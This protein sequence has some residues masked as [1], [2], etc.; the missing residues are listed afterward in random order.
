MAKATKKSTKKVSLIKQVQKRNGM[1]VPFDIDRITNAVN[2]AMIATGEGSLE[3]AEMVANGVYA[4][5]VRISKK[6]KNFL[7]TV[8]GIQNSVE[9]QLMLSEYIT[10]AKAY[11]LYR[12]KRS[13]IRYKGIEVPVKVKQLAS[14]SKKDFR[15]PL[16][17]FVY[18]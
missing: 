15:N 13:A 4:D 12:E 16:G 1:I 8:E 5:L 18:Y 7:P 10:T 3:E 17:E 2:K 11:I 14:D 6:H 9:K